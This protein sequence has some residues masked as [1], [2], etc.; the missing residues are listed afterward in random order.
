MSVSFLGDFF[1]TQSIKCQFPLDLFILNLEAPVSRRGEPVRDKI[2]LR[3]DNEI[4]FKSVFGKN[5]LAVN[6]ANN[7][8]LDFGTEAFRDT[9]EF[10]KKRGIAYFGAGDEQNNFNNPYTFSYNNKNIAVLG[11]VSGETNPVRGDRYDVDC[12]HFSIKKVKND[13]KLCLKDS[14]VVVV[15]IHWGDEEI[16]FPRCRN[17]ELA[18][19]I[20]NAGAHLIVGHHAHVIQSAERYK[21]GYIYYGLGNFAFSDLNVPYL[22][23]G[24][25]FKGKYVKKLD[26]S[27]KRSV[28]VSLSESGEINHF[29]TFFDGKRVYKKPYSVPIWYPKSDKTYNFFKWMVLR[30]R[31]LLRFLKSPKRIQLNHIKYFLKGK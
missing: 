5:P 30:R 11:Y 2:N 27:N 6:L 10:L 16:P 28:V 20:I 26:K 8:I 19:E 1:I 22:Y 14:D 12:A 3:F 13:I 21:N 18:H 23:D 15:N 4:D 7:H 29:T 25:I 31:M 24:N 17:V 9:L